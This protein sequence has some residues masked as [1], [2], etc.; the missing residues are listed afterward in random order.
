[1]QTNLEGKTVLITGGAM[2]IGRA[3]A[4]AFAREGARLALVDI[5]RA[6]LEDVAGEIENIGST[7]SLGVGDLSSETG[8]RAAI[9]DALKPTQG[10]VDVLVNNV[11]SGAVRTFDELTD[12]EWDKTFQLNFMSYVRAIRV[13]LPTMRQSG[14]VIV[15]NAS[16]LARPPEAV[17]ID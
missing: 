8:V 5:D 3:T 14:G 9:D 12:A 17:P 11:G 16:D 6:A 7:A 2:G 1:M 13:L 15:N 4:L 10:A